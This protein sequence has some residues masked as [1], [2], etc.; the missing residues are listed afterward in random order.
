[1]IPGSLTTE[2]ELTEVRRGS[3]MNRL[4]RQEEIENVVT[5]G[6]GC[7]LPSSDVRCRRRYRRRHFRR[8]T[9]PCW[10]V[11]SPLAWVYSVQEA[12]P[13]LVLVLVKLD[14]VQ[15]SLSGVDAHH[16]D[17]EYERHAHRDSVE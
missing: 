12:A 1:M 6:V 17:R 8:G 4:C 14:V 10:S 16:R 2:E 13:E 15:F 3:P 7:G 5:E 11:S 9:A